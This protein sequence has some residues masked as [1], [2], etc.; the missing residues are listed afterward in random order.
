MGSAGLP[1]PQWQRLKFGFESST[2]YMRGRALHT[3]PGIRG[4]CVGV[5]Y[6]LNANTCVTKTATAY[7]KACTAVSF[8]LASSLAVKV[9]AVL[10]LGLKGLDE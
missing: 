5:Q 3:T 8:S 7:K 9:E 2:P 6:L 10:K 4:R 1:A